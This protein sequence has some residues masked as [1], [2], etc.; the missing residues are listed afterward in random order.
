M[1][2]C[3]DVGLISPDSGLN[4]LRFERDPGKLVFVNRWTAAGTTVRGGVGPE[5]GLS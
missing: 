1:F 4:V 2:A 3:K 5:H